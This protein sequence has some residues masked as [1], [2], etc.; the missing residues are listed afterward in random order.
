MCHGS[1]V[2]GFLDFMHKLVG[3]GSVGYDGSQT[4]QDSVKEGVQEKIHVVFW[5]LTM[6]FKKGKVD[7]VIVEGS[8]AMKDLGLDMIRLV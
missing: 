4:N 1:S 3:A 8:H 5:L 7:K 2:Q 6:E